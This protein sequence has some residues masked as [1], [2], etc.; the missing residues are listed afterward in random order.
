MLTIPSAL[1][2]T[3]CGASSLMERPYI[4]EL[5]AKISACLRQAQEKSGPVRRPAD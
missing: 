4:S 5:G 2:F 1:R 3:N